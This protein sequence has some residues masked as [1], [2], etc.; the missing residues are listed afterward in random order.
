MNTS[1][2]RHKSPQGHSTVENTGQWQPQRGLLSFVKEFA[3][4][5]GVARTELSR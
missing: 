3:F 5:R 4:R 2:T 1:C